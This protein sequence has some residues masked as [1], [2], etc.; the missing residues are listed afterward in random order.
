[1]GLEEGDDLGEA[2]VAHVLKHTQD[3]SLEEDLGGAET[4]L[5][6][7]HLK[8]RQDLV[9]HLLAVNETLGDGVGGQDGVSERE[10]IYVS[11]RCECG[12]E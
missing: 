2:L 1:M 5:V 11:K 10:E 7:V 8:G 9:G 3:A 12:V 4:V 6:R